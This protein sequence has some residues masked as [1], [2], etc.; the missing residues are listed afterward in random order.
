MTSSSFARTLWIL[1]LKDI[2][3]EARSKQTIAT[4]L[5]FGLVLAFIFAFGF[6]ADP[7]TNLRVMPGAL[8]GSLLFTGTLGVGRTFAQESHDG[9]FAALVLSPAPR[10][11]ILLAKVLVN[12]LL[13]LMVMVVVIPILAVMLHVD[14]SAHVGIISMQVALGSLAFAAVGTPLAV[15]AVNARFAEVLLPMVIF[16]MLTPVLI[17]GVKSTGIVLGTTVG[18]DPWPWM[19]FMVAYIAFFGTM[20][21]FLFERMVTE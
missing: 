15:V 14:L 3:T 16:P 13:T 12:F 1:L 19:Q 17:A 6:V 2:R 18:I 20:G 5:L 7:K 4:M 21:L 8:W 10:A 11:A 9:A